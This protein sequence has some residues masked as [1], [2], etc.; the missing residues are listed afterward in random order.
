[1]YKSPRQVLPLVCILGLSEANL[2]LQHARQNS[3]M[4][5]SLIR[6]Q[7]KQDLT[8]LPPRPKTTSIVIQDDI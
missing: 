1:M 5:T 2:S 4:I 3:Q 7:V 6:A 8:P